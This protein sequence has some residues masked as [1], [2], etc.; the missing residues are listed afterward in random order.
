ML[1]V[2]IEP[3]LE[4]DLVRLASETGRSASDYVNEALSAYLQDRADMLQALAVLE[5][6][7]PRTRLADVRKELGLER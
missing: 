3:K 1:A 6:N 7:E 2:R 5:R 4:A